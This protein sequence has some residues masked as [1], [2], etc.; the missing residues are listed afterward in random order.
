VF[1]QALRLPPKPRPSDSHSAA[2]PQRR[3]RPPKGDRQR[4]GESRASWPTNHTR[5]REHR[6]IRDQ[7]ARPEDVHGWWRRDRRSRRCPHQRQT[8][9][10]YAA[11]RRS[12]ERPSGRCFCRSAL[13]ITD[14]DRGLSRP[15]R[16]WAYRLREPTFAAGI[17]NNKSC[18]ECRW[19]GFGT[20]AWQFG[21]AVYAGVERGAA[22]SVTPSSEY[23]ERAQDPRSASDDACARVLSIPDGVWQISCW[24]AEAFRPCF[25]PVDFDLEHKRKAK[26]L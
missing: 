4:F 8:P 24:W 23:P 6:D 3:G 18:T 21:V 12:S 15:V 25:E 20:V 10:R 11:I 7:T 9:D 19:K 13:A 16:S 14:N 1:T 2:A 22:R 5:W 26:Q 17:R